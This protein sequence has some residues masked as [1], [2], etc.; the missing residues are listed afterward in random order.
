MA[1]P[2]RRSLLVAVALIAALL[3]GGQSMAVEPD[4]PFVSW[5]N[6]LYIGAQALREAADANGTAPFTDQEL[7]ALFSPEIQAMRDAVRDRTLP[8]TEPEGP[9]LDILF[10]WGALPHRKIEILSVTAEGDD[11]AKVDLTING[12]ARPLVLTG[13]F[14]TQGTT[15]QI[16]DIDYGSGGPDRSLRGRLERM[17]GWPKRP[18][19]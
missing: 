2:E 17:Q 1:W 11:R 4:T 12:N 8:T 15:W 16:D 18:P 19:E 3:P 6:T 13:F 9:I 10:G 7:Q 5:A 14:N